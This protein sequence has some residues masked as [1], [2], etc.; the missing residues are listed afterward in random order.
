MYNYQYQNYEKSNLVKLNN[1]DSDDM[2]IYKRSSFC[3]VMCMDYHQTQTPICEQCYTYF[4]KMKESGDRLI[5]C[6]PYPDKFQ[7]I[8]A[9][10]KCLSPQDMYN[11]HYLLKSISQ[12]EK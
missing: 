12:G 9:H 1:E 6:I 8:L 7:R 3:G 10:K 11:Y 5:L 4:R 2:I